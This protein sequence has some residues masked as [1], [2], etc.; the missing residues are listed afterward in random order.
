MCLIYS[1]GTS[2]ISSKCKLQIKIPKTKPH[3]THRHSVSPGNYGDSSCCHCVALTLVPCDALVA[4]C[5]VHPSGI[6]VAVLVHHR[7][8]F[9]L[10]P[11]HRCNL[12]RPQINIVPCVNAEQMGCVGIITH[13]DTAEAASLTFRGTKVVLHK[14]IHGKHWG[15]V[16]LSSTSNLGK[17]RAPLADNNL[18][19]ALNGLLIA[20][21]FLH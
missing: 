7:T 8:G 11:H 12:F 20:P 6:R 19:S 16:I 18:T 10:W 4:I 5:D 3:W 21:I 13:L 17:L 14:N 2:V 15:I 9:V 1:I